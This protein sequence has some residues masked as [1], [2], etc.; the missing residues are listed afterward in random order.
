MQGIEYFFEWS[1]N[2]TNFTYEEIRKGEP[3]ISK[4]GPLSSDL[5]PVPPPLQRVMS[6]VV[7][8]IERET[9]GGFGLQHFIVSHA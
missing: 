6:V 3:Y 1:L 2:P 8:E 5:Y 9:E 4:C 7:C